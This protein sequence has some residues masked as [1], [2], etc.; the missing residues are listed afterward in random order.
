MIIMS[1]PFAMRFGNEDKELIEYFEKVGF[2][3]GVRELFAF[4]K[5]HQKAKSFE[6]ILD[7]KLTYFTS[8]FKGTVAIE[9]NSNKEL[10][11]K[12]KNFMTS[13]KNMAK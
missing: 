3:K 9:N 6:T 4:Y 5:S 7:E 10:S 2:T 8:N 12:S 13:L 11:N 1:K